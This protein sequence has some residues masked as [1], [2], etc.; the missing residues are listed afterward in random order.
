MSMLDPH[1]QHVWDLIRASVVFDSIEDLLNGCEKFKQHINSRG[2]S[3][4]KN[5]VRIK[6]GFVNAFGNS[7]ND[8]KEASSY[9]SVKSMDLSSFDYCDVK[10][11]VMVKSQHLQLIGEVQFLLSFMLQA[12]KMGHSYYSF[13]RK[14][15][16][17]TQ[18]HKNIN[19]NK[20]NFHQID[21]KINFSI[22]AK[23]LNQLS[24]YLEH[25]VNKHEK[26]YV[27]SNKDKFFHHFETT[28][29]KKGLKLFEHY[30]NSW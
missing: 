25:V 9:K 1:T 16:L 14:G 17:F 2:V 3:Y 28:K 7:I 27:V 20:E 12:K 8:E 5:V 13:V 10:M 22:L 18:I 26:L 15:D 4:I 23:N 30:V 6:N 24:L 19:I 29:W 21:D 11:N